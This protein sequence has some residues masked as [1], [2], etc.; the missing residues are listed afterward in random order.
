MKLAVTGGTGFVGAHL[1]ETAL[2]AGHEV[3]ALT[4]RDQPPRDGL[5][6]V[7][8]SL[9]ERDA[10]E[11]LVGEADAVIHVAGVINA[12]S[13][14]GFELGNVAGTLSMLAA[15]TAGGIRRFVHVSSLAAREP[16]LSL[17]GASKKRAE[18]LV[19]GSGLDWAIVRPPAVYGPGDKETLELFRMAKLGLML[20]PPKGRVSIIHAN[21]LA[22]LLLALAEEGAPSTLLVEADDG[23]SHGWTH[24]EFARALG[25]AVGTKPTIV[26]SPGILL[27]LAA[28]ADQLFRGPHAKLT[29]DRAA[30][31]S[32]KNWVVEPKRACPPDVWWP[33][34]RTDDGLAQTAAWYREQG[35]L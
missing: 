18:D 5:Q 23:K 14:A 2:A 35:W 8:G 29:V 7:P 22:R 11:A 13:A 30:Y 9:E 3:K 15:A 33:L 25:R 10:L 19:F 27:R 26:S 6:W 31:F 24:R 17:Y 34:I 20:M 1:I 12:S 28:R 4:R 32:H 16:K 21:D